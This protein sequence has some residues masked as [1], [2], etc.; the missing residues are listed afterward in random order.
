MAILFVKVLLVPLLI[1][2]VTWANGKVGPRIAGTIAALP[3][4]A[5]PVSLAIALEQGGAFAAHA[6]LATLASE[7][8][9][10]AFCVIYMR[11]CRTLPWGPSLL[12]SYLGFMASSLLLAQVELDGVTALG[13]ALLTPL[14]IVWLAPQ[15]QR[16]P[17][18]RSV[19]HVEVGLRMLAGALMVLALTAAAR[20]LGSTWSGLLTIFPIATSVLAASSQR[21][22][23]PDQTLHLLRGLA[24]GLYSLTAFFAALAFGLARWSI[25][26]AYLVALGAAAA[27]QVA[28]LAVLAASS[29]SRSPA[30]T[31]ARHQQ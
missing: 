21:S 26:A 13:L 1:A 10:A 11:V 9:L 15:P 27:A 4:V 6:A 29:G 3:M 25:P 22:G 20:T 18:P 2:A 16:P 28:L 24:A 31:P 5:G 19:P 23:G 7:I 12:V 30:V 8:S 14:A 17:E